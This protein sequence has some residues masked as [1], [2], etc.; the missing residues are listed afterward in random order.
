MRPGGRLQAAI[1]IVTD[2]LAH[3][4]P[5]A[6]AI[7]D[8]GKSHR[9]AGSGDRG[10]IGTLVYDTLR[11][12]ASSAHR[13]GADTPRAL[14]LG[15]AR[16]G[17]ARE[18]A[19]ELAAMCTGPPHTPEP[20]TDGE[21]A[22]LAPD[23]I[24]GAPDHVA[25][26]Y[27]EWLAPAMTRAFGADAA[28]EGAALSQ[29][30]PVDV[31]VNLLKSTP[32]KV[33]A[34]LGSMGAAPTQWSPIG[35]RLPAPAG[36]DGRQPKVES[37]AAH[38]KGWL[39][40][41]DEGS[42]IAALM[43]NAAPREQVLDLCAGAGGKTL[44]MAAQMQNTGQIFAYDRDKAQLRPIFERLK[45]AGARNVQVLA[46]GDEAALQE[47]GPRF[48]LVLIDAPCSGSGTW[49]RRPDAKWRIR[50]GQFEERLRDQR[51][52]LALGAGLVK[53]GG[54]LVYVTCS[55]L[56]QENGDQIAAVL[57]ANP[58]L[59]VVPWR[60][61]WTRAIGTAPPERSADGGED[62]LLLTPRSHGTDGFFIAVLEK[63]QD[64]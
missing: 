6:N 58:A 56:P 4:R 30:A 51:A 46:G 53:P 36:R 29:R 55:V 27:P 13:M 7:A 61:A 54:R 47:L 42:Q 5:A 41:Q 49:R 63:R 25:G 48:D 33:L 64:A 19:A 10:A 62:G 60:V 22:R 39:E 35:V 15:A 43:A 24:A 9:F 20:L 52:V 26:N 23:T 32:D 11:L 16:D 37:D 8:W 17:G 38:G 44:A 12:K 21:R 2:I 28:A 40:V 34:S 14:V 18:P 59:A 31:R 45:R 3:Y 1:E 50:P 57:A